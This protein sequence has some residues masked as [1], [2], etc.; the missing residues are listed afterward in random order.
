M[1]T[2]VLQP[3]SYGL[4]T[5]TLA[6]TFTSHYSSRARELPVAQLALPFDYYSLFLLDSPTLPFSPPSIVR[7]T[8]VCLTRL[9]RAHAT[10]YTA[11][12]LH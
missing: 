11:L 10:T 3:V 7:F 5:L 12:C 2:T 8:T 9:A 4:C 1:V 6:L